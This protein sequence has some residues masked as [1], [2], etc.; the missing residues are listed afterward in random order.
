MAESYSGSRCQ[1]C[2]QAYW[3][4]STQMISV[5]ADI[6]RDLIEVLNRF[7]PGSDPGAISVFERLRKFL[8]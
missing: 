8:K 3:R 4:H 6:Y 2:G 1:T 7:E 5:R